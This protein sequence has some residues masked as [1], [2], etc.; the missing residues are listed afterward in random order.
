[1][2]KERRSN[3]VRISNKVKRPRFSTVVLLYISLSNPGRT[4]F[5]QRPCEAK[6]IHSTS[7]GCLFSLGPWSFR[8]PIILS[9][10][11]KGTGRAIA[12]GSA[13]ANCR[14]LLLAAQEE[15]DKVQPG[16]NLQLPEGRVGKQRTGPTSRC[17]RVCGVRL[18]QPVLNTWGADKTEPKCL[19]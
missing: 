8:V 15:P 3:P 10:Y 2:R 19:S 7:T 4:F 16:D 9:P 6:F 17:G 13:V 18:P 12:L 14:V 1:M 11:H 5:V